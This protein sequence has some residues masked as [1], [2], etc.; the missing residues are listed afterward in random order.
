MHRRRPWL[1]LIQGMGFD[2]SG[3]DPVVPALRRRFRTAA[4]G[5]PGGQGDELLW[6]GVETERADAEPRAVE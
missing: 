1:V 5:P 2:H 6:S 3:W 4:D